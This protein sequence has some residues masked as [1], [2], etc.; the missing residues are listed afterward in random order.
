MAQADSQSNTPRNA[1]QVVADNRPGVPATVDQIAAIEFKSIKPLLCLTDEQRRAK[2]NKEL[3]EI[4]SFLAVAF[5]ICEDDKAELV[6]KIAQD[7]ELWGNALLGFRGCVANLDL[8][9]TLILAAE[10][11]VAVALAVVETEAA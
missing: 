5:A 7:P 9:K 4:Y 6:S 3:G 2:I 1:L 11:R 10:S 8:Y